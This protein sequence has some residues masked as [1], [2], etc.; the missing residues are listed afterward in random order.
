MLNRKSRCWSKN[1]CFPNKM[2]TISGPKNFRPLWTGGP[3]TFE[4]YEN[5]LFINCYFEQNRNVRLH[6]CWSR[7]LETFWIGDKFDMLVIDF[8]RFESHQHLQISTNFVQKILSRNIQKF[9]VN[10]PNYKLETLKWLLAAVKNA[11]LIVIS[12]PNSILFNF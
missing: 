3:E 10:D 4:L 5:L 9:S 6:R 12:V 7:M 11:F 1:S 2:V 8:L